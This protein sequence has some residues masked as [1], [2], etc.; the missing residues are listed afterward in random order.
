MQLYVTEISRYVIAL[1]MAA[2]AVTGFLVF[3]FKEGKKREII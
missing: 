3:A 2:Y 1:L